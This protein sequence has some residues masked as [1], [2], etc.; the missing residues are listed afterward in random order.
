MTTQK[1]AVN[2]TVSATAKDAERPAA[3]K[4]SLPNMETDASFA[5]ARDEYKTNPVKKWSAPDLL[6][7]T[8]LRLSRPRDLPC[9]VTTSTTTTGHR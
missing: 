4:L 9:G 2:K 8:E 7:K 5:A 1:T 3:K 6:K